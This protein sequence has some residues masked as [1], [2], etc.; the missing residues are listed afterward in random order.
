MTKFLILSLAF[1]FTSLCLFAQEEN[2]TST[3]Q[4]K[5]KESIFQPVIIAGFN[6]AQI[7]GDDIRGYRRLGANVGG[8]VFIK[9]PKDFSVAIEILYSMKGAKTSVNQAVNFSDVRISMDYIDLPI[10]ANYTLDNRIIF[11]LGAIV[12]TLVRYNEEWDFVVQDY[13]G[14]RFGIEFMANA[15]FKFTSWFGVNARMSYSLTNINKGRVI[16]PSGRNVRKRSNNVLSVRAMFF[17]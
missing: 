10:S 5:E 3:S 8:G 4:I 17:F 7:E 16:L 6:A 1:V 13:V 15:T 12:N 2:E 9:L 11:G 14:S